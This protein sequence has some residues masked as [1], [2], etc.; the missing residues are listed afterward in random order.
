MQQATLV[1]IPSQPRVKRITA[2]C[3]GVTLL[4][5]CRSAGLP[6]CGIT[7]GG[8]ELLPPSVWAERYRVM[9]EERPRPGPWSNNFAPLRLRHYGRVLSALRA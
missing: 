9:E 6:L 8:P 7:G 1:D 4:A 3:P 5:V 2:P